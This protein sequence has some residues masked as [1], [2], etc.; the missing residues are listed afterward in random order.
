MR[1][2]ASHAAWLIESMVAGGGL[3]VLGGA[4]QLGAD[5]DLVRSP[6]AV[7]AE[8]VARVAQRHLPTAAQ[9]W[10][11]LGLGLGVGLGLGLGALTLT[12]TLP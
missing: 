11:G 6:D 4:G 5:V 8:R 9:A 3:A 1:D 7:R 2:A 10:L 12:L